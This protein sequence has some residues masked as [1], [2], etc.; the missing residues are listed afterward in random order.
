MWSLC[1]LILCCCLAMRRILLRKIG[2]DR[3]FTQ[4][5]KL[6]YHRAK[7]EEFFCLLIHI[8]VEVLEKFWTYEVTSV[9]NVAAP[10]DF[11]ENI[12]EYLCL[13]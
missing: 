8:L 10:K 7:I 1:F 3:V 4:C 12:E 13:R 2:T 5:Y 6:W 9:M 11:N